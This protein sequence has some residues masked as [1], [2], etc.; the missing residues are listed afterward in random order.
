[1]GVVAPFDAGFALLPFGL[2]VVAAFL[3]GAA[4][5]LVLGR[6]RAGPASAHGGETEASLVA[7]HLDLHR[8]HRAYME[9][10]ILPSRPDLRARFDA[11]DLWEDK[12]KQ[13]YSLP[14]GT[15]VAVLADGR[16]MVAPTQDE[17]SRLMCEAPEPNGR[18]YV[19]EI[20]WE[21]K[22]IVLRKKKNILKPTFSSER[23]DDY[24][25]RIDVHMGSTARTVTNQHVRRMLVDDA[26][27]HCTIGRCHVDP[28]T[29][30]LGMSTAE[31][32]NGDRVR[33]KYIRIDGRVTKAAC[34]VTDSSTDLAIGLNVIHRYD[35]EIRY[36]QRRPRM[37]TKR[38]DQVDDT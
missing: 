11:E 1:M 12:L 35:H 8:R 22:P 7:H 27:S 31:T 16:V 37:W 26:A 3:L 17:I 29:E 10:K 5:A 32:S 38:K 4:A 25:T 23:D 34:W 20:G 6:A 19:E 24:S 13:Q 21:S 36:W 9:E 15:F 18:F 14:R 30:Y 2:V 33:D 28:S